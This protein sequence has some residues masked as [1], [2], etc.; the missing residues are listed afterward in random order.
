MSENKN[1]IVKDLLDMLEWSDQNGDYGTGIASVSKPTIK[2]MADRVQ[3]LVDQN[4]ELRESNKEL[5]D[6]VLVR[7]CQLEAADS[8]AVHL[9]DAE[10]LSCYLDGLRGNKE[11]AL[12]SIAHSLMAIG[13]ELRALRKVVSDQVNVNVKMEDDCIG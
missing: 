10:Q 7:D 6:K 1:P 3:V 9:A 13:G 4:E 12:A 5:A 11:P 8:S 2:K